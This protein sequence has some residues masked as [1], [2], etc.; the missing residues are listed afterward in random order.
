ME[1]NKF[2]DINSIETLIRGYFAGSIGNRY[3]RFKMKVVEHPVEYPYLELTT[4]QCSFFICRELPEEFILEVAKK[5]C[6]FIRYALHICIVHQ[7]FEKHKRIGV[8]YGECVAIGNKCS[9]VFDGW[10]ILPDSDKIHGNS[11]TNIRLTELKDFYSSYSSSFDDIASVI[12]EF[13]HRCDDEYLRNDPLARGLI[14]RVIT[15]PIFINNKVI[16]DKL[17]VR[18]TREL[19]TL[20]SKF[21]DSIPLNE[22]EESLDLFKDTMMYELLTKGDKDTI[23]EI[24]KVLDGVPGWIKEELKPNIEVMENLISRITENEGYDD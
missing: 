18:S 21:G 19:A 1:G 13:I 17:G 20:I 23:D 6:R 8:K 16:N 11:S 24:R 12:E 4:K 14:L 7:P 15:S 10:D 3:S 9:K 22:L 5:E 2:S